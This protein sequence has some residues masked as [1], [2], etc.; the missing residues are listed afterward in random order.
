MCR[1]FD[2]GSAHLLMQ[3]APLKPFNTLPIEGAPAWKNFVKALPG[4]PW[5]RRKLWSPQ[6]I[7]VVMNRHCHELV[8]SLKP[9]NL[10]ALEI[11]GYEWGDIYQFKKFRSANY[12]EYDL[13]A[14]PLDETFDLII[15]EQVFEH[16]LWPYKAVRNV[17]QMLRPGGYFLMSTPF[18]VKIHGHPVDCSRWTPLGMKYLLAEGGFPL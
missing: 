11:S 5:I 14:A 2:P 3:H 1:R 8:E 4:V 17:Y 9:E 18:L 6:W 12:P 10:S 15:A 13:C 16:L 7:R